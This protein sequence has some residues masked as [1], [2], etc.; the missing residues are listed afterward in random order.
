MPRNNRAVFVR[1][2][3][4]RLNTAPQVCQVVAKQ[5]TPTRRISVALTEDEVDWIDCSCCQ[6]RRHEWHGV[7]RSAFVR[8]LVQA[9]KERPLALTRVSSEEEL[10]DAVRRAIEGSHEPAQRGPAS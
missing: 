7:T 9:I 8:A 6:V 4:F 2:S 10:V 3:I 5:D 1:D